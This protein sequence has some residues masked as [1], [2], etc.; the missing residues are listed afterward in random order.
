T[1]YIVEGKVL[2]DY[3]KKTYAGQKVCYFGQNDDFGADGMQGVEKSLGQG[4][5]VSKQNYVTTNTNVAPQIG[6]FKAAGCQ[7]VISFTIPGFTALS[8]GT[9][10]RLGYKAQWVVSSVG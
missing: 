9:A 8:L 6:A 1:D 2:G 3:V 7:V 5:L 10:A 4:V